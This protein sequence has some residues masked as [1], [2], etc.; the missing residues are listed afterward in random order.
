MEVDEEYVQVTV[1]LES[2]GLGR[3]LENFKGKNIFGHSYFM[4]CLEFERN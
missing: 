4:K 3:L 2:V 1:V